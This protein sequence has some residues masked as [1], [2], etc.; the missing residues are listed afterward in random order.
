MKALF[1]NWVWLAITMIGFA[2]VC[3]SLAIIVLAR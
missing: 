3:N 1:D 2:T